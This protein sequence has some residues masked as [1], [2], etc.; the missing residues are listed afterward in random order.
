MEVVGIGWSVAFFEAPR[1]CSESHPVGK[2][3]FC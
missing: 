2:D 3:T 1:G